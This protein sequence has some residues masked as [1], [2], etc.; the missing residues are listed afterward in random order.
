MM[1]TGVKVLS[2]GVLKLDGGSVFGQVPKVAWENSVN[3]RP[4]KS[5]NPGSQ[6]PAVAGGWQERAGG[7]RSWKPRTMTGTRKPW[8][9]CPSRLLKGLKGAGLTP[10]DINAV[11]LTHLH[12]DHCGGCTRLDPGR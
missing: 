2:D 1:S 3:H 5:D 6:L 7:Y 9:W 8:G 4:E 10:K 12:F 11:I